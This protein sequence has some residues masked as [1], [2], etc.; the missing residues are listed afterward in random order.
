VLNLALAFA[1]AFAAAMF[2]PAN[3]QQ[4]RQVEVGTERFIA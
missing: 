1:A 4:F 2:V 3:P